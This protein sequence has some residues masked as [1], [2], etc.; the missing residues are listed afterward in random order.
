MSCTENYQNDVLK[1]FKVIF[2]LMEKTYVKLG[3]VPEPAPLL[4]EIVLLARRQGKIVV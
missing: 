2:I 3:L 1:D 4:G